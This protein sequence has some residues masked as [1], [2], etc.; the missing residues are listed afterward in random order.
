MKFLEYLFYRYYRFQVRIGNADIATFSSML[1]IAFTVM[2]YIFDFFIILSV[3]FPQL[4]PN[5]SWKFSFILLFSIIALLY[6]LLIHKWKYKQIIKSKE[7]EYVGKGKRSFVAIL[8]PLIGFLLFNLGCML[9]ILQNQRR[10][11]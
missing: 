3:L 2:L 8:F 9:K 11:I 1:I 5:L 4:S 10:L 7:K 6:F